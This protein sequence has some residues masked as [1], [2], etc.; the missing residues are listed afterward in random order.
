MRRYLIVILI[1]ISIL[2][3]CKTKNERIAERTHTV[4]VISQDLIPKNGFG[5]NT[6]WLTVMR[7]ISTGRLFYIHYDKNLFYS[8]D[9][10]DKLLI[11]RRGGAKDLYYLRGFTKL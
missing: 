7:E 10:G 4:I 1:A 3:S 9:V 2:P 6:K 8:T 11:Q 5:S